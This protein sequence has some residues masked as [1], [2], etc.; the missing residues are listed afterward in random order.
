[1]TDS[2]SLEDI[3]REGFSCKIYHT[4]MTN[5]ERSYHPKLY[6]AKKGNEI[7]IIIGSSNLTNRGF[8]SND[9]II[10]LIL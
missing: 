6:I 3:F 9:L 4:P 10:L 8:S 5:E 2:K 1:M 7:K